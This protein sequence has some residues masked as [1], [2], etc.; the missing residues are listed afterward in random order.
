MYL[1]TSE[2]IA[3]AMNN[4]ST[5]M[6]FLRDEVSYYFRVSKLYGLTHKNS[7]GLRHE[8]HPICIPSWLFR[9]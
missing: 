6:Y 2:V 7:L 1:Y 5:E 3:D 8:Y 4:I 9:I